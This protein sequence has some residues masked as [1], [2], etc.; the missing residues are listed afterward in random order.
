MTRPQNLLPEAWQHWCP[1]PGCPNSGPRSGRPRRPP[2]CGLC[3]SQWI[4][5]GPGGYYV[6]PW[7]GDGRYRISQAVKGP[8]RN[9]LAATVWL[10]RHQD[11]YPT[12]RHCVRFLLYPRTPEAP[13]ADR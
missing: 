3:G 8:Y 4:T 5:D 1:R 13:D 2:R 7:R 10:D 12:D 9:Q 6:L 11:E